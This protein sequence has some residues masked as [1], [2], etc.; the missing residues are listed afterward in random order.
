[1]RRGEIWR[2][3]P[4]AARPGQPT[5]RLIVSAD[6]V[7]AND[8][9]PVVLTLQVVDSDPGSLL[10]VRVNGHGWA[11]ALSIEP[12]LRSRLT[13]QVGATDDQTMEQVAN[14]LRAVQDL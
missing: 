10:A 11:R 5:L 7:N 1:V 12:A 4:V 2:Y 8:Q 9:V 13:G 6:V 3:R 14:A